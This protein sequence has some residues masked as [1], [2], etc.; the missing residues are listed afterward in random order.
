MNK[1]PA[2]YQR[3]GMA[4]SLA[5]MI[6]AV[7]ILQARIDYFRSELNG[8]MPVPVK[9]GR[10]KQ[11]EAVVPVPVK[12]GWDKF[13]T[14][15]ARSAEIRRRRALWNKPKAAKKQAA[16]KKKLPLKIGDAYV[17][18]SLAAK[19]GYT[20]NWGLFTYLKTKQIPYDYAQHNGHNRVGVL[21]EESYR[22]LLEAREAK[23]AA[24]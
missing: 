24:A 3:M 22:K 10:P 14:P 21:S 6:E 15:E 11:A 18:N 8:Q 17:I 16:A 2:E 23:A 1:T 7:E 5:G 9:R 19:L 12:S 13:P 20:T 4:A